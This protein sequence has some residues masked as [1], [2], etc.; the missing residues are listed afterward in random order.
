MTG[1]GKIYKIDPLLPK[2]SK[3]NVENGYIELTGGSEGPSTEGVL[4]TVTASND[5][6]SMSCTFKVVAGSAAEEPVKFLSLGYYKEYEFVKDYPVYLPLYITGPVTYCYSAGD[7][8]P[9][10]TF[11]LAGLQ[12]TPTTVN[13]TVFTLRMMCRNEVSVSNEVVIK[14]MVHSAGKKGLMGNFWKWSR[15]TPAFPCNDR[16]NPFVTPGV[17]LEVQKPVDSISINGDSYFNFFPDFK[18]FYG[19]MFTG[20]INIPQSR[21]YVFSSLSTI[22]SYIEI[23]DELILNHAQSCH[24][25]EERASSPV[26]LTMGY[27]RI[28]LGYSKRK[29][30]E[31]TKALFYWRKDGSTKIE[32]SMDDL[33]YVPMNTL[34]YEKTIYAY[35]KKDPGIPMENR[36]M[37]YEDSIK[38]SN[39]KVEPENLPDGI[40]LDASSGG[41]SGTPTKVTDFADFIYVL[42]CDTNLKDTKISH[43]FEIEV[44]DFDKLPSIPYVMLKRSPGRTIPVK[45]DMYFQFGWVIDNSCYP[46]GPNF[47]FKLI[48]APDSRVPSVCASSGRG[49]KCT[50]DVSKRTTFLANFDAGSEYDQAFQI[51]GTVFDT[52]DKSTALLQ[53][54]IGGDDARSAVLKIS[55][56][57]T[58]TTPIPG[59][60]Y[61]GIWTMQYGLSN[62]ELAM[63]LAPKGASGKC[64][65]FKLMDRNNIEIL[66]M[67]GG[68]VD[69][70]LRQGLLLEPNLYTLYL[71]S[72]HRTDTP[73][74]VGGADYNITIDNTW[75]YYHIDYLKSITFPFRIQRM[76]CSADESAGLPATAVGGFVEFSCG[77]D[78]Y[79][80][81][82][83]QCKLDKGGFP[84]WASE[85]STCDTYK[86]ITTFYYDV[87]Y[88]SLPINTKMILSPTVVGD[89]DS[90]QF[91]GDIVDKLKYDS[92]TGVIELESTVLDSTLNT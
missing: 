68:F 81:R 89:Y 17:K 86:E 45:P 42:T 49:I 23:D 7:D 8:I 51:Y 22:G 4:Y 19:V 43:Q 63:P 5:I 72:L 87:Q 31:A 55:F 65:N 92:K 77:E 50:I 67:N 37:I 66:A 52:F 82:I 64:C 20:Y 40:K 14:A 69:W 15:Y 79:G 16:I 24:G 74:C 41:L 84:F 91:E 6:S 26:E 73:S 30:T 36:L 85:V 57:Y 76:E 12:G 27:H 62:Q 28:T 25:Q 9:G 29:S 47:L 21:S 33:T 75:T 78:Q 83:R 70:M 88:I 10:L 34:S 32:I 60:A 58:E 39:C 59:W 80:T 1:S 56:T 48:P 54:A 3:L 2:G 53:V 13:L 38:I 90:F 18:E 44:R 61:F 46:N 11:S 71:E 35:Q